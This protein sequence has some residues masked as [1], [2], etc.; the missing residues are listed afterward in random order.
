VKPETQLLEEEVNSLPTDMPATTDREQKYT[1]THSSAL[2]WIGVG[3]Q[4][5]ALV[6][7]SP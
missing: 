3:G 6:I 7:L 2:L 4:R 5:H 1:S